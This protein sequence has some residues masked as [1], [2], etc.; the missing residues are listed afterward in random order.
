V[1]QV[2]QLAIQRL[3]ELVARWTGI[4]LDRG[5]R[6]DSLERFLAGRVR[7]LGLA[8]IDAYVDTLTG[9]IH[10]EVERLVNAVTVGHT[11]F[12]RDAQQLESIAQLFATGFPAGRKLSV[13][14]AGCATGEDVYTLAMLADRAG[15]PV[16]I[17]GT[18]IN[19]DVIAQAGEGVYSAWSVRD[20]PEEHRRHFT[21]TKNGKHE[22]A[23]ALR[24]QVSFLRH[25]LKDPPPASGAWDLI[26]CRNV[27]IY[28]SPDGA[29]AIAAQLGRA[30]APGGWLFIG[31]SELLRAIP[32]ELE[33]QR[34]GERFALRR[35]DPALP[36]P[37]P[38]AS[39][40]AQ[41]I[42]GPPPVPIPVT[43]TQLVTDGNT[44]LDAGDIPAAIA[45]YAKALE[46]EPL[47]TEARLFTGIAYHVGGDAPAAVHSLRGALFLDPELWPAAYYLALSYE[48]LGL[49]TEAQR[50]F[51]RVVD[52]SGQVP[53]LRSRSSLLGDLAAWRRD[54]M[55]VAKRRLK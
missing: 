25:N 6:S 54:V 7:A 48:K 50:E 33:A 23:A 47:S 49:S 22:V 34:F 37:A 10:P 29:A 8:S 36:L 31:A 18:D 2:S 38:A 52:R 39:Q 42:A 11:W 26:L 46:L 4:D 41:T 51:R 53:A 20:V 14:V 43:A 55:M 30:L 16:Q 1:T 9:A 12:F 19:S 24:P 27:L 21:P 35:R 17:L 44:S 13:W 45:A 40:R 32:D 5:G 28:F 15:R 3:V